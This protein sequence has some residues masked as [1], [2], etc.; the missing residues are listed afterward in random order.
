LVFDDSAPIYLQIAEHI[1][2]QIL[3]GELAQGDQVMSTTQWATT[4]RINPATAAKG[5]AILADEGLLVKRR[6]LGMFVAP[7][8][9]EQLRQQR[10]ATFFAAQLRPVLDEAAA[11]GITPDQ[12]T[13]YIEETQ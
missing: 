8:A 6:G 12:I 4:Y 1:R 5:L 3:R 7:G 10:R 11:L 13:H 2:A 9:R